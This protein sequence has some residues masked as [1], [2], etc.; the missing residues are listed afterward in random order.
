MARIKQSN[1][2]LESRPA[3]ETCVD[4][5][6]ALQLKIERETA[7]FNERK[8]AEDK[9][10]KVRKKQAEERLQQK[11]A[12]VSSYCAHHR[13]ELL[14]DKQTGETR[15]SLF[16]YRKSPGILKPLNTKWSVGKIIQAL[17]DAGKTAC[18]KVTET[19]DKQAAKRE[20]PEADLPKFGLRLEFGE[21]FWI[22]PKRA[23]DTPEKRLSA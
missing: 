3:F 9:A 10:F 18:I 8:A 1:L 13:D 11:L 4:E 22:E 6:G 2:I 15:L 16:G 20:I 17:K 19:L 5:I 14:G 23:E 12:A 21:E 7:E